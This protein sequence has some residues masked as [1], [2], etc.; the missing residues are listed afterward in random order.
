[1]PHRKWSVI[2]FKYIMPALIDSPKDIISS[3]V[4]RNLLQNFEQNQGLKYSKNH[5]LK[6]KNSYT[7]IKGVTKNPLIII[8]PPK[9]TNYRLVRN[10]YL[11][12]REQIQN[13]CHFYMLIHLQYSIWRNQMSGEFLRFTFFSYTTAL[14]ENCVV[15]LHV[16]KYDFTPILS[17]NIIASTMKRVI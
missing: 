13:T 4:S 3:P 14:F 16:S 1:M 17:N 2:R 12:S 15:Q 10:M 8:S 6:Y 9:R 5:C 11:S 7:L